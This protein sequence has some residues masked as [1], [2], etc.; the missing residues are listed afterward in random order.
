MH[1]FRAIALLI[2]FPIAIFLT[3]KIFLS[4]S[5][6][7][8]WMPVEY[9][10]LQKTFEE[11]ASANDFGVR[12]LRMTIVAGHGAAYRAEGLTNCSKKQNNCSFYRD[13]NPF[14]KH[15]DPDVNELIRQ[16]DLNSGLQGW[17]DE[18]AGGLISI[19]RSSIY[20]SQFSRNDLSCLLAH[21]LSHVISEEPF[22]QRLALWEINE[23]EDESDLD[24][25]DLEVRREGELSADQ[26]A[27]LFLWRAGY[28]LDTCLR[29]RERLFKAHWYPLATDPES[30]YFG[31]DEW[32]TRLRIFV[33]ENKNLERPTNLVGTKGRWKFDRGLNVLTFIPTNS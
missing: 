8:L 19:V 9:K 21:E 2:S 15:Q 20:L 17:V 31:Y 30:N 10:V 18:G 11:L 6:S 14:I 7:T 26:D 3:P 27:T 28:P 22:A 5:N 4:I 12:P 32:M 25:I 24:Q 33:D 23:T 16:S 29:F 13:F 1:H